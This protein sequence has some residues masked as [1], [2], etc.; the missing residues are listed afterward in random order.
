MKSESGPEVESGFLRAFKF[1]Q[2][3][4]EIAGVVLW[5]VVTVLMLIL[6]SETWRSTFEICS[7]GLLGISL[8]NAISMVAFS[9]LKRERFHVGHFLILVALI[10][11]AVIALALSLFVMGIRL[12]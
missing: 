11:I 9:L 8:F 12:H 10:L 1:F 2:K 5:L 7:I 4:A 6:G 3:I